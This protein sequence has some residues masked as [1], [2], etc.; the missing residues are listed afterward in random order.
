MHLVDSSAWY[1]VGPT[2]PSWS[3]STR[4]YYQVG[5]ADQT[6]QEWLYSEAPFRSSGE[7]DRSVD[8]VDQMDCSLAQLSGCR[9][10][11]VP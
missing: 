6:R 10:V 9:P 7:L 3:D 11:P 5:S 8:L 2:L 4:T 1:Q